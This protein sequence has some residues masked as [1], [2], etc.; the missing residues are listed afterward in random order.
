MSK[1]Q[2]IIDKAHDANQN[3]KPELAI[4]ALIEAVSL[5][6]RGQRQIMGDFENL[7][8]GDF[9]NLQMS[10]RDIPIGIKDTIP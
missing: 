1:M 3:S 2:D 7:H 8:M 4:E 6:A 5:L 10:R 9:E